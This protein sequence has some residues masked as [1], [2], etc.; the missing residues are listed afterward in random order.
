MQKNCKF[1][2]SYNIIGKNIKK[3]RKDKKIT[4]EDLCARMQVMGY[5]ISRSDISK[6]ENGKKFIADF[7]AENPVKF[8]EGEF[9]KDL[10]Y[11]TVQGL[12]DVP[13]GGERCFLCYELRLRRSAVLS[14]D[15]TAQ[16]IS[17]YIQL[18]DGALQ[19]YLSLWPDH[20]AAC[21][22]AA[23]QRALYE[24]GDPLLL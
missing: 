18:V 1:N 6:L 20:A 8:L 10:F 15:E 19:A 5:Q 7:P 16:A 23:R 12:E 17:D 4:Q 2:N 14:A 13:E 21:Q 24:Q 11:Q 22:A 9:A 3:I